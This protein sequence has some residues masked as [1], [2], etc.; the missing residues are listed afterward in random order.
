[1]DLDFDPDLLIGPIGRMTDFVLGIMTI[2]M[3]LDFD[4]ALLTGPIDGMTDFVQG[5]MTITMIGF[6]FLF[7]S[8]VIDEFEEYSYEIADD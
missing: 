5:I 7:D 4:R 1:M 8:S 3:D 2:T 6:G